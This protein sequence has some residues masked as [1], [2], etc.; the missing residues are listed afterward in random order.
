MLTTTTATFNN[1]K[2]HSWFLWTRC[3]SWWKY[4]AVFGSYL[5]SARYMT[6]GWLCFRPFVSRWTMEPICEAYLLNKTFPIHPHYLVCCSIRDVQFKP[7]ELRC[8][9]GSYLV[10]ADT[11]PMADLATVLKHVFLK[12]DIRCRLDRIIHLLDNYLG[13]MP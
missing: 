9:F 7:D 3:P 5:V 2:F 4:G 13:S 6:D 12:M 11:R 1:K 10:S 8:R